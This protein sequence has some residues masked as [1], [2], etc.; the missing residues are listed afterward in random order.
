MDFHLSRRFLVFPTLVGVFLDQPP[1]ELGGLGLPHARGG[2]SLFR[3]ALGFPPSSSPRSW[4]CFSS[5]THSLV[6]LGVFPTLVGVFLT[7]PFPCVSIPG[8]PHAR[9]G[10]SE[11]VILVSCRPASSPR[12][13]GC[14]PCQQD[15]GRI[16]HVFPTLVGV[17]LSLLSVD[18][19][20]QGLPHARGGVSITKRSSQDSAGSSPRSWGCF[21][22]TCPKWAPW[23]VF[24]T[25]VGVFLSDEGVIDYQARL[26]HARGG[27]SP[28]LI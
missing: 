26:P 24:P 5:I 12:S 8:L 2:V 3:C 23:K 14:F 10:V 28:T 6:S 20:E 9:G 1:V 27:V 21:Y 7:S 17:F 19:A 22:P 25:L 18:Y 16:R 13:W 15:E 11:I 4:G